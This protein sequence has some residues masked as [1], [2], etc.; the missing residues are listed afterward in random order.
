M[1]DLLGCSEPF[2]ERVTPVPPRRPAVGLRRVT[3]PEHHLR[4]TPADQLTDLE[5]RTGTLEH[6]V[7]KRRCQVVRRRYQQHPLQR[8]TGA[9][10]G[11]RVFLTS[12]EYGDS[13]VRLEDSLST[14]T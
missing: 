10:P 9:H 7:E 3:D 2:V 6:L 14:T 12:P 5:P 8:K 13:R 11:A 1:V 4:P